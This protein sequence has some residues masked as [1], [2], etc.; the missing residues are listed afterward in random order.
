MFFRHPALH[1]RP[2]G[3]DLGARKGARGIEAPQPL[4]SKARNVIRQEAFIA[5]VSPG[6][7]FD[8]IRP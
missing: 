5:W 4:I 2:M 8:E 6:A 7:R 1:D 3:S